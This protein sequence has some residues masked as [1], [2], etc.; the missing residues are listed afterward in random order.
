MQAKSTIEFSALQVQEIIAACVVKTFPHYSGVKPANI[1][2]TV[3][4]GYE[5][6]FNS[7]SPC[8]NNARVEIVLSGISDK[9]D[10]LR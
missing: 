4:A 6:R 7:S 9:D 1:K 5:D 2:F 3:S 10:I 8:L